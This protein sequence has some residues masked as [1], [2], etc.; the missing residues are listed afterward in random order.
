MRGPVRGVSLAVHERHEVFSV[1]ER[2]ADGRIELTDE[3]RE[4]IGRSLQPVEYEVTSLGIRTFA[5]A[6]GYED[7]IYFDDEAARAAGHS[8][9]VA[10][11]GY[12]GMP[13]WNPRADGQRQE[14]FKSPFTRALNGGTGVEPLE[15]VHA[16]DVLEATT[17]LTSVEILPSKVYGQLM[18]RK[19][20]TTYRRVS[21]GA[22]V[23]KVRG[24]G[25][26]Y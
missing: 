5:R 12:L 18:V 6:V 26:A 4:A 3:M 25:L 20:E 23:A 14:F 10:P 15:H 24:T 21:D 8:S 9:I 19:T 17:T 7:P 11:P 16:G 22:V 2:M 13:I 1:E